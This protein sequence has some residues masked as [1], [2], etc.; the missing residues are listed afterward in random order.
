MQ[1]KLFVLFICLL[2]LTLSAFAAVK[3]PD[4][5]VNAEYGAPETLD[6]HAE[7]DNA[8]WYVDHDNITYYYCIICSY[9]C[10]IICNRS[11]LYK[12]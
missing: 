1:K 10:H 6:P 4:T 8:C 3:D 12:R 9:Y 5:I 11:Y 7:W 2:A